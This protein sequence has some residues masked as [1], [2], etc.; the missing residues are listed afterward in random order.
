MTQAQMN[1]LETECNRHIKASTAVKVEVYPDQ[2]HP[3]V[4][5]V[6]YLILIF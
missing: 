5:E 3:K 2:H 1:E 4:K 6:S